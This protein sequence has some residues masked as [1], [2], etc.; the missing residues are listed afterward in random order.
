M[1]S[2][3]QPQLQLSLLRTAAAGLTGEEIAHAIREINP[4][5][6]NELVRNLRTT[7]SVATNL[8]VASAMFTKNNLKYVYVM[9]NLIHVLF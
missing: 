9:K 1:L 4:T 6:T 7:N 3:I 2:P 8:G 5:I